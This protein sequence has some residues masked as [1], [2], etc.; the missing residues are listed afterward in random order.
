MEV[1]LTFIL[2]SVCKK[3][4]QVLSRLKEEEHP[5]VM[6]REGSQIWMVAANMLMLNKQ[7]WTT[8]CYN[9]AT[10]HNS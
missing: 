10:L 4:S 6:D 7:L 2:S 8:N 5:Q 1:T 3:I 9:V